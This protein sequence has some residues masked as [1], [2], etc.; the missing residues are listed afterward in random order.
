MYFDD[1]K[2]GMTADIEPV[3]EQVLRVSDK[4]GK[5][6]VLQSLGLQRV[7]HG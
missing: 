6:G 7:G 2:V 5:P 3:T 1:L 4:T